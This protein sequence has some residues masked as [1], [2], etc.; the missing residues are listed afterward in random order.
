MPSIDKFV[1]AEIRSLARQGR[2]VDQCFKTFQHMVY[3]GAPPDQIA[4][5][6]TCFFAGV[7]ECNALMMAGLDDGLSETDGDLQFMQQWVDEVEKFHKRTIAAM[8]AR[9]GKAGAQ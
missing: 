5:M 1:R 6:R 4:E 3:P 9:E 2:L 8:T 7:A